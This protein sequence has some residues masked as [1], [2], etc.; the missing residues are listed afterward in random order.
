MDSC[1]Q[2]RRSETTQQI[3]R[4]GIGNRL[5]GEHFQLRLAKSTDGVG[6]HLRRLAGSH[7]PALAVR[8]GSN[9][10]GA[11]GRRFGNLVGKP[12]GAALKECLCVV[13][14]E[15]NEIATR[16]G[17][18]FEKQE[19]MGTRARGGGASAKFFGLNFNREFAVKPRLGSSLAEF[20]KKSNGIGQQ[21]YGSVDSVGDKASAS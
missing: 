4:V 19:P 21:L 6:R 5:K 11:C 1:L 14:A 16:L 3:Q 17:G 2:R 20:R 9:H 7:T 12:L 13:G 8:N 10:G 18:A 15:G